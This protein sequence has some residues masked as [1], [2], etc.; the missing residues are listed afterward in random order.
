MVCGMQ[1]AICDM[2]S[3]TC[4]VRDRTCSMRYVLQVCLLLPLL[5]L[6]P[7][8]PLLPLLLLLLLPLLRLLPP[9]Q[10]PPL[11]VYG[12]QHAACHMR[13]I[14]P[15][16]WGL[17]WCNWVFHYKPSILGYPY[18]RKHPHTRL[19]FVRRL[20]NLKSECFFFP[21]CQLVRR[22]SEK[23]F[24]TA[25]SPELRVLLIISFCQ[26]V[27]CYHCSHGPCCVSRTDGGRK[28]ALE[29]LMAISQHDSRY[30][31]RKRRPSLMES[32][33]D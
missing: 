7:L 3:W 22:F 30:G 14:S 23:G 10:A 33:E 24:F 6:L 16:V 21:H 19:I 5:P 4:S 29:L 20:E 27:L 13:L 1:C 11:L 28:E 2:W 32:T 18:F 26:L 9:L 17:R 15:T 31:Q 8:P 25:V 12:M